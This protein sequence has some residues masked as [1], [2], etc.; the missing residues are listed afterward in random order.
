MT[1]TMPILIMC[2]SADVTLYC[3]TAVVFTKIQVQLLAIQL[4]S[5]WVEFVAQRHFVA[6]FTALFC[7]VVSAIVFKEIYSDTGVGLQL[8]D[9]TRIIFCNQ[10]R[11]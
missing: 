10:T 7:R 3:Y 9:T 11:T 6:E 8:L 2:R 4:E 5:C 1:T